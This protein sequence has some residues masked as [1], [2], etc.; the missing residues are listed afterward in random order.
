MSKLKHVEDNSVMTDS[1]GNFYL[2]FNGCRLTYVKNES[3]DPEEDWSGVDVIRIQ[4]YA[5][6]DVSERLHMGAEIP[7]KDMHSI[8]QLSTKL[9]QVF[10][11]GNNTTTAFI[12]LAH[13]RL[14]K[15]E[16]RIFE[17]FTNVSEPELL[18]FLEM[19]KFRVAKRL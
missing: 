2:D 13:T 5:E 12:G 1:S 19:F 3:R 17:A 9:S 10:S 4:R 7:V 11:A 8:L 15:N 6:P 16:I 18:G 14:E